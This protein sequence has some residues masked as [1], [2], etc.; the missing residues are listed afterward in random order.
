MSAMQQTT[1][2]PR[3][4]SS[5][6]LAALRGN[7][8]GILAMLIVQFAIGM[9]VNLYAQIPAA[10]RGSGIFGAVGRAL[11]NGPASLAAHAGLGLLIV[12]AALALV[13][14]SILAR[15]TAAIIASV[16]GALAILGA[17]INGARFVT[18][19]GQASASLAM[20]LSTAVA[21]LSY[22]VGLLLLGFARPADQDL[23]R[24][25]QRPDMP[26]SKS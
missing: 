7:S 23:A 12:L 20:A 5:R 11:T 10:D 25:Q 1:P 13:V 24:N 4:L 3:A 6:Q 14:R 21:M 2:S 18:D 8:F 16:I 9:W 22:A 19:G 17:A 26:A 15:H